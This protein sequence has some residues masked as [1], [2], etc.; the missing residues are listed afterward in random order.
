[1]LSLSTMHVR[2]RNTSMAV[3][4]TNVFGIWVP[5]DPKIAGHVD[6]VAPRSQKTGGK[7]SLTIRQQPFRGCPAR[8]VRWRSSLASECGE[9]ALQETAIAVV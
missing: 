4:A 6:S 3:L 5:R 7:S 8:R 2:S 1:M 9:T